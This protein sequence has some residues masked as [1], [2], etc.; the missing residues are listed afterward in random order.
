MVDNLSL[1]TVSIERAGILLSAVAAFGHF[2][3]GFGVVNALRG[4]EYMFLMAVNDLL[5]VIHATV[6]NS[7]GIPV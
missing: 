7:D 6:A 2:G 3:C 1:Q 4:F 5:G